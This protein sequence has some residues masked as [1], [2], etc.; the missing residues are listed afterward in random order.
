MHPDSRRSAL[1]RGAY[2]TD[3]AQSLSHFNHVM[4]RRN[5][6][7]IVNQNQRHARRGQQ[8]VLALPEYLFFGGKLIFAA[9]S[10]VILESESSGITI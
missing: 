8:A 5:Q 6:F 1:K 3:I 9:F 7:R 10:Q 2:F 4:R